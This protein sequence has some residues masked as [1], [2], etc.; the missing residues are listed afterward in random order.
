MSS[1][2]VVKVRVPEAVRALPKVMVV[3][4]AL[5]VRCESVFPGVSVG[6]PDCALIDRVPARALKTPVF[7]KLPP[8]DTA[9]LLSLIS[10]VPVA[11]VSVL[12]TE[13]V[14]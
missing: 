9:Q 12:L 13:S 2:P 11:I 7:V 10:K 3:P 4:V 8:T 5:I 1:V 14:P 6:D